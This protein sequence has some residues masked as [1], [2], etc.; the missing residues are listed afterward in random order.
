MNYYSFL[1]QYNPYPPYTEYTN[2][3]Y[4]HTHDHIYKKK[5][6]KIYTQNNIIRFV[7][8]LYI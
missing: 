4:I 5:K 3:I 2:E 8:M 7:L 1:L 6:A